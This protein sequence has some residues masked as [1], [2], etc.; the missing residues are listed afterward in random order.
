MSQILPAIG[1]R[2]SAA[3]AIALALVSLVCLRPSIRG[4]DG[5]GNY[6]YLM[7]L[8]TDGDFD[9]SD[10]YAAFDLRDGAAFR[11]A[12]SPRSEATGLPANRYGIGCALF[13][14][15]T[16]TLVHVLLRVL[17][18][19]LATGLGRPY[20]WAVAI[21]SAWW[22][23]LGLWLLYL[24]LRREF[25]P[26]TSGLALAGMV[27]ATPLAFYLWLH[28]SMSHAVSFFVVVM[29]MLALEKAWE[30]PR[31]VAPLLLGAWCGLIAATR[32]QDLTWAAAFGL[33]LA[34]PLLRPAAAGSQG[35][36]RTGAAITVVLASV[37]FAAGL[38]LAMLPQFAVWKILYGRW[39][40]G[41]LPYLGREGGVLET[42]PIHA[43]E[44]LVSERGGF[45]AW[46]PILAVA[47]AGWVIGR[48]R[49]GAGFLTAAV[50]GLL[51]QYYLVASWSMWWG[52]ASF[53]NRFFISSYPFFV[54][55]L[56]CAD[57]RLLAAGRRRVFPVVLAVLIV[58]NAGLLVQYGTEMIS[59]EKSNGWPKVIRNQFTAVPGWIFDR[60]R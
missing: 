60:V 33:A 44:V 29:A 47:I 56:A 12:D 2:E 7:S 50:A 57:A 51:L 49:L 13:W 36:T 32:F 35:A 45:L 3:V 46:H 31:S 24:R 53:G 34:V 23:C 43:L 26:R 37:L 8:L 9:F 52:G 48:R 17:D 22:G 10:E 20:E 25:T 55:G 38:L 18:P 14:A 6:V 40:S 58:W 21:G 1:K 39:L 5:S 28:G 4:Q 54:L 11:L 42:L 15:P 27:F 30:S 19:G 16:V 59:R 41:P